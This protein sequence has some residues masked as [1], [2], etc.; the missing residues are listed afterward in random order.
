MSVCST[1]MHIDQ[2]NQYYNFCSVDSHVSYLIG[3]FTVLSSSQKI[4]E[5]LYEHYVCEIVNYAISRFIQKLG[6]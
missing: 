5:I 6:L 1:F 2:S 3:S 4:A